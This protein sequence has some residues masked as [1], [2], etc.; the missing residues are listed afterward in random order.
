[1]NSIYDKLTRF[2]LYRE[3]CTSELM[4]KMYELEVKDSD[5]PGYIQQLIDE[6]YLDEERFVKAYVNDKI[7][8]KKWGRRKIQAE[9][10]MKKIPSALVKKYLEEAN[11]EIYIDNLTQLAEKK[12]NTLAKKTDREKQAS[13]FRYMASKGYETDLVMDWMKER[14]KT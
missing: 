5:R 1:M 9:L 6:K 12:W 13:L 4:Q 2:C 8:L 3:R 11:D 10:S 7:Y 14:R